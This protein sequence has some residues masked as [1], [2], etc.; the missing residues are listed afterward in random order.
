MTLLLNLL[1][2]EFIHFKLQL[3]TGAVFKV[4]NCLY[5]PQLHSNYISYIS[6]FYPLFCFFIFLETLPKQIDNT[7]S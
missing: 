5:R 1:L 4:V 3:M 2:N 6:V 7:F